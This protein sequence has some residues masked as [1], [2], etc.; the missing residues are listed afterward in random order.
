MPLNPIP[1]AS[2]SLHF[3]LYPEHH[4]PTTRRRATQPKWPITTLI[5]IIIPFQSASN[6]ATGQAG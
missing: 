4:T 2:M 3:G 1:E 6:H 5:I